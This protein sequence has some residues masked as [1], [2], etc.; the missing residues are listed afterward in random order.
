MKRVRRTIFVVA[1]A[2]CLAG[3]SVTEA[4]A[5]NWTFVPSMSGDAIQGSGTA[6]STYS[7]NDSGDL[8]IDLRAQAATLD[9]N[10]TGASAT[11]DVGGYYQLV[12]DFPAGDYVATVTLSHVFATAT[13]TGSGYAVLQFYPGVF[14]TGCNVTAT[15]WGGTTCACPDIVSSLPIDG[16]LSPSHVSDATYTHQMSVTLQQP[17]S[18]VQIGGASEGWAQS[19]SEGL[20]YGVGHLQFT[21]SIQHVSL[22]RVH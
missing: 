3:A 7:A 8:A 15:T 20:N 5:T 21:G 18:L 16:P 11:A 9:Q 4:S 12:G 1:I 19:D 13:G 14:C 17:Q 2:T 10:S 6:S 22:H